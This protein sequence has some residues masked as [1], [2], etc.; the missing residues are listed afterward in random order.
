MSTNTQATQIE[1][2]PSAQR[3]QVQIAI[4]ALDYLKEIAAATNRPIE[5]L[6]AADLV[7]WAGR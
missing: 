1:T 4:V 6:T 7:A 2:L 5:S 3:L